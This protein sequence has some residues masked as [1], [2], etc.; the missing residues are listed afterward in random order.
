[1][2]FAVV[3]DKR[4]VRALPRAD[5]AAQIRCFTLTNLSSLSEVPFVIEALTSG[6]NFGGVVPS[7]DSLRREDIWQLI[8]LHALFLN[9][10]SKWKSKFGTH[11][12]EA[13]AF[14]HLRSGVRNTAS[15]NLDGATGLFSGLRSTVSMQQFRY[16][17]T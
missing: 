6:F 5:T 15:S 1:M 11:L 3:S 17:T 12:C 10:F 14:L 13:A 2:P 8:P 7:R 16:D 4:I 9:H